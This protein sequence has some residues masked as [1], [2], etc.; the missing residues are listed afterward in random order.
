MLACAE[1]IVRS[2]DS[3]LLAY[4]S[5]HI[6]L[7]K[8]GWD[9]SSSWRIKGQYLLDIM[10]MVVLSIN[11][12][13]TGIYYVPVSSWTMEKEGSKRMEIETSNC[14]FCLFEQDCQDTG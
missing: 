11:W 12:D 7:Q 5:G 9:L 8:N 3:N 1:G 2:A 14:C 6:V 4:N 13:Q 10:A